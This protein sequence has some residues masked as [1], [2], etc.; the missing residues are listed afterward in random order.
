M[1]YL[2]L[3]PFLII[4]ISEAKAQEY[5]MNIDVGQDTVAPRFGNKRKL[6]SAFYIGLGLIAGKSENKCPS[7]INYGRSYSFRYGYWRRYKISKFYSIGGSFE[8]FYEEYNLKKNLFTDSSSNYK[9]KFSKQISNNAGFALFNRFHFSE[10][11]IFIDL[12]GY[13]TYDLYPKIV[14]KETSKSSG[15]ENKKSIYIKP[16]MINTFNYGLEAKLSFDFLSIYARYR[17]S[18]MYNNNQ[19]DLP[20]Y[21]FGITA[22]FE[23]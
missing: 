21:N 3:L 8:Y 13:I 1:N 14:T 11:Y 10:D 22:D 4:L 17:I 9:L 2:K 23:N 12:G 7:E 16:K 18:E 20:K 19:G 6:N 15:F 5:I